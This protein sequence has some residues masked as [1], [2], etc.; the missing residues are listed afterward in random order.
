MDENLSNIQLPTQIWKGEPRGRIHCQPISYSECL[1][2]LCLNLS[3]IR[4]CTLKL[5]MLSSL[6]RYYIFLKTVFCVNDKMLLVQMLLEVDRRAAD[7]ST[8]KK[9]SDNINLQPKR[10]KKEGG[11][12]VENFLQRHSE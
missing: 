8:G 7:G 2:V 6:N 11:N 3:R 10:K 9:A 1:C 5:E 12:M 4:C